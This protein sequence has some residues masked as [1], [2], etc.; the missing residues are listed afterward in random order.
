MTWRAFSN[1]VLLWHESPLTTNRPWLQSQS[2]FRAT[3]STLEK[4]VRKILSYRLTTVQRSLGQS[5]NLMTLKTKPH[6]QVMANR[7]HH[8]LLLLPQRK[9][10]FLL[11]FTMVQRRRE[12][13]KRG[14]RKA[15]PLLPRLPLRQV[16][17]MVVVLLF[18]RKTILWDKTPKVVRR[19]ETSLL[20]LSIRYMFHL[21][22]QVK[23]WYPGSR[24]WCGS[25]PPSRTKLSMSTSRKPP[26]F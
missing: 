7:S 25:L 24:L 3:G 2:T 10:C 15:I 16:V 1:A 17:T 12:V 9:S 26:R 22:H 4:A 18:P 21:I 13:K 8:H 23:L 20:D 19:K 6:H 11:L 5:L 14:M